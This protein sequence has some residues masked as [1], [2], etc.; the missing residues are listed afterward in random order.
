MALEIKDDRLLKISLDANGDEDW[1]VARK[2]LE[3]AAI[4]LSSGAAAATRP[5]Q[6]ALAILAECGCRMFRGGVYLARQFDEALLI[7]SDASTTVGE[8][9][10][11]AGCDVS[12]PP[13]GALWIHVGSDSAPNQDTLYC[14]VDGWHAVVSPRSGGTSTFLPGN[15]LSGA[16]AGAMAASAAFR[17]L[18][19][20][21]VRA[22][23]RSQRFSPY[24]PG[25]DA[26][27]SAVYKRLPAALWFIGVGN[28]GQAALRVTS[29]LR[30]ADRSKVQLVLHDKDK[31]GKENLS[32][33]I[34]T[35]KD[36]IGK[37]KARM[38]AV[39]ADSL[40]FD[41]QVVEIPFGP[42][43]VRQESLPGVAI[44]GVDNLPARRAIARIG[45]G[46][47]IVLDA[48]LGASALEIFDLRLHAFPGRLTPDEAWREDAPA[49]V[50]PAQDEVKPLP[51]AYKKLKDDGV[52]DDCGTVT[53]AGQSVGVPS[54]AVA[55]AV[56]QISQAIR[57][58]NEGRVFDY[59]DVSLKDPSYAEASEIETPSAA[60]IATVLATEG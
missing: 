43:T 38:A 5:G 31:A 8:L 53:L 57:L 40:G 48:G 18:V 1:E 42:E 9:L 2:R 55:A 14:W 10:G 3:S 51:A 21:D 20:N 39:W 11:A 59:V 17:R 44:V 46:F 37:R 28:L 13:P 45:S 35:T 60:A 41:T 27:E 49:Q 52:L 29:L 6:A 47:Q 4:V 22:G 24:R 58:V 33:Q 23:K 15:E 56:V 16:L 12:A 30:Y 50:A 7:P 36:W 26:A 25:A 54:T 19:M 34:L 32:V